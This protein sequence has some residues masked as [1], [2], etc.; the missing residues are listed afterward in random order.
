MMTGE[1]Y[2]YISARLVREVAQ[3]GGDVAGLVPPNVLAA[4]NRRFKPSAL[5]Q[6]SSG[7]GKKGKAR[8]TAK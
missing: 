2:F 3:F 1:D 4:L 5:A 8:R 7:L 6:P